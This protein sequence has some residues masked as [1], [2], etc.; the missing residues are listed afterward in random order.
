MELESMTHALK[1][2]C[3]ANWAKETYIL[4][5]ITFFISI[6]RYTFYLK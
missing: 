1:V 2:R 6:Q 5:Y 3:S 4:I